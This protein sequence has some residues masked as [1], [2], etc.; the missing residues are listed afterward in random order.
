M[1]DCLQSFPSVQLSSDEMDSIVED[2]IMEDNLSVFQPFE[3]AV[4]G[5]VHTS[6]PPQS[7]QV[8]KVILV[9]CHLSV[10]GSYQDKSRQVMS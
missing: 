5:E 3:D 6:S 8:V 2:I 9:G 10:Q 1:C 4:T 7:L